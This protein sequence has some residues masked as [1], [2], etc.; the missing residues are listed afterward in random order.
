MALDPNWRWLTEQLPDGLWAFS[1]CSFLILTT[2]NQS[3]VTKVTYF[4]AGVG[5]A[6][7]IELTVGTFDWLDVF[8]IAVGFVSAFT[9]LGSRLPLD[10][11]Q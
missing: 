9:L 4:L 10:E 7:T 3:R 6:L 2:Q 1:L 8:A 11:S 5:I